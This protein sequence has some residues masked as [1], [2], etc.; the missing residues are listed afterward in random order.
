MSNT[1]NEIMNNSHYSI[2]SRLDYEDNEDIL[3]MF[4][5]RCIQN[6]NPMLKLNIMLNFNIEKRD[7]E[8][9]I[10][11]LLRSIEAAYHARWG[12][13][14]QGIQARRSSIL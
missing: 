8:A 12:V 9:R 13:E 11:D 4:S 7:Y 2:M 14:A 1:Y 10:R 6:I 3:N 5:V